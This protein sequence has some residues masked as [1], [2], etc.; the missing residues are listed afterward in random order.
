MYFRLGKRSRYPW[1]FIG[2]AVAAISAVY[3]FVPNPKAMELYLPVTAAA[4]GFVH[5]LYSQHHQDSQLFVKLFSEFNCRY[6]SL[7]AK[8]NAIVE[9]APSSFLPEEEQ[10]LFDYFN[11]CAEEYLFFKSGYIDKDVWFAW[12][13]GMKWFATDPRIRDLWETELKSGS[14]YNFSLINITD[15]E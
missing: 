12:A 15:S 2:L 11:L 10:V 7:N 3:W 6:D 5:F 8:L 4:G 1:I 14:Y 9:N 13:N